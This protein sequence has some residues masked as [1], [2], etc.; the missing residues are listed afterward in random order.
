MDVRLANDSGALVA[1]VRSLAKA[2]KAL[3]VPSER[4]IFGLPG[5]WAAAEAVRA[6]EAEGTATS[7]SRRG[8][9][10]QGREGRSPARR[11]QG[12]RRGREPRSHGS[13]TAACVRAGPLL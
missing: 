9:R 12:G 5:T 8:G 3:G 1:K 13:A 11:P 2:Y 6:L 4:L 7:V 10:R